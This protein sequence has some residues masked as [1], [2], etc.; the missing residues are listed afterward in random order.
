MLGEAINAL[1]VAYKAFGPESAH[2]NSPGHL[3][4]RG[5]AAYALALAHLYA[6][7]IAKASEYQTEMADIA[8]Q[9][10][11]DRWLSHASIVQ[12]RLLRERK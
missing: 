9:K 3:P 10:N 12:S 6:G 2:G 7:E 1:S 5:R 4:Y 8:A 11:D